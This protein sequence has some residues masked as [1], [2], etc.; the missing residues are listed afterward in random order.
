M[1][2]LMSISLIRTKG[3][4]FPLSFTAPPA[5]RGEEK[6]RKRRKRENGSCGFHAIFTAPL[7]KIVSMPLLS[8]PQRA[9]R[10]RESGKEKEEK[11]R[12]GKTTP[13]GRQSAWADPHRRKTCSPLAQ[14]LQD[15]LRRGR[16]KKGEKENKACQAPL[17]ARPV[18]LSASRS[19]RLSYESSFPALCRKREKREKR[20]KSEECPFPV[21]SR[22][23]RPPR[24]EASRVEKETKGREK[25]G[26]RGGE[27]GFR[28][29]SV[30]DP[31]RALEKER[32]RREKEKEES[33]TCSI[34][35]TPCSRT[36]ER[37][38]K[39]EKK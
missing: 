18:D 24:R 39:E 7:V 20:K 23:L 6:K 25:E 37:K 17:V 4:A 3:D 29:D 38:R 21:I 10:T 2:V 16:K 13:N 34:F 15:R 30:R 27:S 31:H 14:F 12:G 26:E 22:V 9:Q 8:L 11:E 36:K 5:P 35:D 28:A 32:E 19:R 1:I 33:Y